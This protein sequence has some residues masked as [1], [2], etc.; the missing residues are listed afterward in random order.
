LLVKRVTSTV[1]F[2]SGSITVT[3]ATAPTAS[4][5]RPSSS[6]P[7]ELGSQQIDVG[8]AR[9]G[10]HR[11]QE[12]QARNH[13]LVDAGETACSN[14]LAREVLELGRHSHVGLYIARQGE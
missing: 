1:H 6:P 7:L 2:I 12:L 11:F 8:F 4:V 5:P 13:H 9:R 3:S 14:F 10:G